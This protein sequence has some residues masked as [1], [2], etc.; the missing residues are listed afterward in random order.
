MKAFLLLLLG[1]LSGCS[2][3]YLSMSCL[4]LDRKYLASYY[5]K[6]PDPRLTHPP[7]GEIITM[8]WK[9]PSPVLDRHPK[10]VLKIVFYDYSEEEVEFPITTRTGCHSYAILGE[11]YEKT[12]G[13]L[14][15]MG[16]ILLPVEVTSDTGQA[17][18]VY[19]ESYLEWKHQLSVTKIIY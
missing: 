2:K 14:S 12:R 5:V 3:Y 6:T 15:F 8:E 18:W 1:L 16:Q 13:V 4:D 9:I 19:N 7:Q 17:E 10:I 11:K